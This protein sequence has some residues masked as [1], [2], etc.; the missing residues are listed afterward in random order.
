M[1][2]LKIY[3]SSLIFVVFSSFAV[4]A[5]E[6]PNFN[7]NGL[8]IGVTGN[9]GAYRASGDETESTEKS[10]DEAVLAVSYGSV[11]I[12]YA[13]EAAYG[14]TIGVDYVPESLDAEA[15]SR[16]DVA[17][18]LGAGTT[19]CVGSTTDCTT[20]T[21]DAEFNDLTTVYALVP[22][23]GSNAFIKVGVK[24]VDVVSMENL[25]TGSTYGDTSIDGITYGIGWTKEAGDNGF[26][27]RMQADYTEF[28]SFSLTSQNNSDNKVTGEIEG[29]QASFSIGKSF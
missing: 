26:F 12:E 24:S 7:A 15:T 4:N 1:N 5:I 2:K 14:L 9:V 28:D 29:V 22:I 17:N 11:F 3:I 21:V 19:G 20:N 18:S 8:A 6:M 16:T 13:I 23:P 27:V 10:S 25:G